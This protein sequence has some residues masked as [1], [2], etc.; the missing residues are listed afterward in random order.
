MGTLVDVVAES[1][2]SRCKALPRS[3]SGRTGEFVAAFLESDIQGSIKSANQILEEL[4]KVEFGVV[5][6]WTRNGNAYILTIAPSL[7][8]LQDQYVEE[9]ENNTV[10][11]KLYEL[12][13]A[14]EEWKAAIDTHSHRS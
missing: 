5:P 1:G 7:V 14:V 12:R 11:L 6:S 3:G 2:I 9:E 10:S 13:D 4:H 8:L